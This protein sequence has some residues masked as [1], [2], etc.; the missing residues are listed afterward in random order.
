[1]FEALNKGRQLQPLL[2]G[3]AVELIALCSSV[4]G[5]EMEEPAKPAPI[6]FIIS[7]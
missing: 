4:W 3:P 1:M 7:H 5:C 6:H 2:L